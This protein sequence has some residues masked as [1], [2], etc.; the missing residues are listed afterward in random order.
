MVIWLTGLSG[1]GKT[2]LGRKVYS[3]IKKNYSN[4][5]FID[6]DEIREIFKH[7]KKGD[8]SLNER[9]KNAERICALCKWLDSQN[10]NVV[11]CILSV[12]EDSRKWNRRNFSS[13]YE[14]YIK[15]PIEFLV[16]ERDYKGIYKA[17]SS[18]NMKNVVGIDLEFS[19]PANPDLVIENTGSLQFLDDQA[20]LIVNKADFNV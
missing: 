17:A 14:V 6:G 4:T 16:K 2:T 5:V 10:I 20:D 13:Y 1:A 15:A 3:K 7:D 19:E 9:R 8:Y 11:C 12:F 18:G